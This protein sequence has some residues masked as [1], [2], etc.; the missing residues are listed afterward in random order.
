[1][2]IKKKKQ[3]RLLPLFLA[4]QIVLPT[5]LLAEDQ[6]D[7]EKK[8]QA[9][10]TA[11]KGL[12]LLNDLGTQYVQA[13]QMRMSQT[14][15]VELQNKYQQD[16]GITP[17]D[18]SQTPA[19]LSQ[20]GCFVLPAR[21]N[22]LSK[23]VDC[24]GSFDISQME[25][26]HYDALL[27]VAEDNMNTIEN[28]LV[29]GHERLTTQGIGCYEKAQNQ[30]SQMLAA[31]LEMLE[32][33]KESIGDRFIA[34]KKLSEQDIKDIKKGDALLNG[35]TG[36]KETQAAMKD[37]KWEDKFKNPACMSLASMQFN[38]TG[39]NGGFRGIE[40]ALSQNK[41]KSGAENFLS[42]KNVYEKEIRKIAYEASKQVK[43]EE[44][45]P[46][47]S[48]VLSGI[49]TRN[50]SSSSKALVQSFGIITKKAQN[51]Q[52]DLLQNLNKTLGAEKELQGFAAS[53]INN[54]A[55]TEAAI[56]E[57]EKSTKEA[58][59]ASHFEREFGSVDAFVSKLEDPNVS[60]KA[61]READSAFKNELKRILEDD[62]FSIEEKMKKVAAKQADSNN[63]RYG[64]VSGHSFS[65]E[66][67]QVGASTRLRAS[68]MV[69]LFANDCIKGF[70]KD[71]RSGG[72]SGRQKVN[73]LKNFATKYKKAKEEFANNIQTEIIEAMIDCPDQADIGKSPDSCGPDVTNT[74]SAGFCIAA[75]N[76]CSANALSC[77]DNAK[78]IVAQTRA[79]QET[80]AKRYKANM[81]QLKADLIEEFKI[82]K[83]NFEKSSRE[84]DGLY[85]MGTTYNKN[86]QPLATELELNFTTKEL[87]D[88]IDP[89]LA[90][91]DP[92]KYKEKVVKNIDTVKAQVA[93]HNEQIIQGFEEEIQKY[94][95]NYNEDLNYW[96]TVANN[97]SNRVGPDYSQ[98][99]A[100]HNKN[101]V[102]STNKQNEQI[103]STCD[104]YRNFRSNPCPTGSE[105][106]F[107]SL[108]SEISSIAASI[109][110]QNAANSI[111]GIV[112]S[113]DS[114]GSESFSN[115]FVDTAKKGSSKGNKFDITLD[116]FCD[117]S[118]GIGKDA[119]ECQLYNKQKSDV[120]GSGSETCEAK[121][122]ALGAE[123]GNLTYCAGK[124]GAYATTAEKC[125]EQGNEILAPE[126]LATL[127]DGEKKKLYKLAGCSTSEGAS[128]KDYQSAK[129]NAQ[130]LL[131]NYKRAGL[132]SQ[133]GEI[134]VAACEGADNSDPSTPDFSSPEY[135]KNLAG[136]V[137]RAGMGV[138]GY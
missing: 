30:L 56:A 67:K 78:A 116:E 34:F 128:L 68:D 54:T 88:G 61:N 53:I 43:R 96:R 7:S 15:A 40:E 107:G 105:S 87:T 80:I 75:A 41:D 21:S 48:S 51:K 117:G 126:Q 113:C 114:F 36:D 121:H 99:V 22:R 103:A 100:E 104:K 8:S 81:D 90:I 97:C 65:V 91:E 111:S 137:M 55:D 101:Q 11:F 29:K 1:M 85:Q 130:E 60:K 39:A 132:K 135:Y 57:W 5:H 94:E 122:L 84:I 86:E 112:A 110:D 16:M 35:K 28:F 102:E 18:P 64:L 10:S 63:S 13:H 59:V 118:S 133:L 79:E 52:T 19:I 92:D 123:K 120:L 134:R 17:V 31:R 23:S 12:K 70:E 83:A 38:E 119:I 136:D 4:F 9:M 33:M 2:S 127:K 20:N 3:I 82:V 106:E 45:I 44:K 58:C 125:K 124:T 77:L 24:S 129:E 14:N 73:A 69:N 93:A 42:K 109:D 66:G 32:Q 98:Y 62:T 95:Q 74:N 27:S 72:Y 115:T 108:S 25:S 46:D 37:F 47:A 71:D 26:N 6:T 76:S 138:Q 131:V 49:R 89:S 50:I